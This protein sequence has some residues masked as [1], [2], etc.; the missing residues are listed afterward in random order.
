[1]MYQEGQFQPHVTGLVV[2]PLMLVRPGAK[3]STAA[4]VPK[5]KKGSSKPAAAASIELALADRSKG[6]DPADKLPRLTGA[7]GL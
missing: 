3:S 7:R 1:M 4:E 2:F 5:A 6:K